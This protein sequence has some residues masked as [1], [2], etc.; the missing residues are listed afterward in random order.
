MRYVL[1]VRG[2][3]VGGD[4]MYVSAAEYCPGAGRRRGPLQNDKGDHYLLYLLTLSFLLSLQH[5]KKK[6]ALIPEKTIWRYFVQLCSALDHMHSR[7][8][9]HRGVYVV[10]V[11]IAILEIFFSSQ[12]SSRPMCLSQQRQ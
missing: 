6:K 7:R 5:F 10:C 11:V 3:V 9:M 12:I 8:V 4:C 2:V 1:S